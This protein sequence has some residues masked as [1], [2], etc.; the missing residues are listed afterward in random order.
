M[1]RE[2]A[3]THTDILHTHLKF[4][5]TEMYDKNINKSLTSKC[6]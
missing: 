6:K 3:L 2:E 5:G 4:H 1:S